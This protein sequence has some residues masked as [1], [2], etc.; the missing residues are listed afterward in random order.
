M[1]TATPEQM[2]QWPAPNFTNPV[3]RA[4]IVVGL[5][6]P[7]MVLVVVFTAVRFYGKGILRTALGLDDWMMLVAGVS[8]SQRDINFATLI[9]DQIFSLPVSA[10]AMA[11]LNYGLGRHIWDQKAQWAIPYG[12]VSCSSGV[13]C[14]SSAWTYSTC[15]WRSPPTYFSPYLAALPKSRF[16]SHICVFFLPRRT[17][18]FAIL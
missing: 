14:N 2:A 6:A 17:R 18:S 15:R 8:T 16:A 13:A 12:K 3:T 10:M 5:T 11:S 7:T 1:V 9:C 4:P